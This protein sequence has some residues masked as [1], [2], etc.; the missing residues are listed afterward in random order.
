MVE[1]KSCVESVADKVEE[2]EGTSKA[3]LIAYSGLKEE[4]KAIEMKL[5][6]FLDKIPDT[7]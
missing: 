3:F 7:S 2:I 1:V 5:I 6:W 4:V